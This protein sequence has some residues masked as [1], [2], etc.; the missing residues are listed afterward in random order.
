MDLLISWQSP[1]EG[2]RLVDYVQYPVEKP[3]PDRDVEIWSI[4][5]DWH[6]TLWV[7]T[8]YGLYWLKPG[9]HELIKYSS[10]H[11]FWHYL[12]MS[13]I[14]ALCLDKQDV[15]WI[16][17]TSDGIGR[18]SLRDGDFLYLSEM[19][20]HASGLG[21]NTIRDIY[22]DQSGLIWFATKFAGLH[23]YDRRQD[24]F[25]HYMKA[26]GSF[27]GL[28]SGFVMSMCQDINGV[29]W[30]GTK[31]G[32][33]NRW[34][35]ETGS[36]KPYH[37]LRM[38]DGQKMSHRIHYLL[39]YKGKGFFVGT[40]NEI[41]WYEPYTGKVELLKNKVVVYV[42]MLDSS[43]RL[44]VGT[45][46]GI[47][48]FDADTRREISLQSPLSMEV[49]NR[50]MIVQCLLEDHLH[51]VW[52]GTRSNGLWLF[53]VPND[54]LH[55]YFSSKND[56]CSL[57]GDMIRSIYEDTR[58]NVWIGLKATGLNRFD[59]ARNCFVRI[60]AQNALM[61]K[62]IYNIM[63]DRR[64][65]LWMGTHDGI[66]QYDPQ[67][68]LAES[69]NLDYGLQ[70][71]VYE[72]GAYLKTADGA[73]LLGGQNGF[74]L[75]YPEKVKRVHY[76]AP[77]VLVK[78]KVFDEV[79]LRDVTQHQTVRLDRHDNYVSFEFALLDYSAPLQNQ[80]A[81]QLEGIDNDWIYCGNRNYVSY[82]NIP[83]GT[84]GLRCKEL[85]WTVFGTSRG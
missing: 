55:R 31:D 14:D 16:G 32:G 70:G 78:F 84:F 35:R 72:G 54:S 18:L 49:L 19:Y 75:F 36:F 38:M 81:Y 23:L 59:E 13:T 64:G 22:E 26:E 12:E 52:I 4:Q 58:G 56:S 50:E 28:N 42:M 60:S 85:M 6:G 17:S 73:M 25:E 5:S 69:Y 44:W 10:T 3:I 80:Y 74:N 79:R 2:V 66:V 9:A 41:E 37:Y 11:P 46:K 65:H 53:D 7:G 47:F 61:G 20:P 40:D 24:Q 71:K 77:M 29:I 62:T 39:P 1:Y 48:L 30:I 27:L 34:D 43:Q 68:D 67:M 76:V 33:I 83:P 63:E 8:S 45:S 57:G 21:S 82:T 51:R 15:L